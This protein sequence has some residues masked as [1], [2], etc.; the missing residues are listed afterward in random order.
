MSA[1]RYKSDVIQTDSNSSVGISFPDGTA[2]N[3]VSSTRIVLNECTYDANSTSNA[4]LISLV[5]GT[6]AFVAGKVAHSGD[7][8]IETP[9]ATVGVRGTTGWVQ[10]QVAT[11][12]ANLGNVTYSFAVVNDFGT[13]THGQYDLIDRSGNV[14]ATVSQTGFVTNV[15]PQGPGV[16]P[17]VSTVPMT[18]SQLAFEQDIIRAG[19][20]DANQLNVPSRASP[21][22]SGSPE[23]PIEQPP[24]QRDSATPRS[25]QN[26]VH[27]QAPDQRPQRP[28]QRDRYGG[29]HAQCVADGH[30][31]M[32]GEFQRQLGLGRNWSGGLVPTAASTVEI[33]QPVKVTINDAESINSVVI[34]GSA[35]LN[36]AVGGSLTVS[37]SIDNSGLI[38]LN[39]SGTDPMLAIRGSVFL[40]GGGTFEMLG[41][42]I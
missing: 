40:L 1:T 30:R 34:S 24:N 36:I 7:M 6:F 10:E 14:I 2:L 4:A 20:P 17:L 28:D 29:D 8:K 37:S 5:Q 3:L 39:S 41:P 12:A 16:A 42:A 11:V 23:L 31:R 9:V 27:P 22:S 32:D 21:G 33:T 19:L 15:T 13:N 26:A 25:R 18:N 35:I 38:Q